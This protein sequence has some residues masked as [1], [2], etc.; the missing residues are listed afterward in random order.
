MADDVTIA[1]PAHPIPD[2]VQRYLNGE[3]ITS[4]ATDHQVSRQTIYNWLHNEVTDT[5]YPELVKQGLIAH[6]AHA[7]QLLMEAR[8]SIDVA[9]AR[10]VLNLSKWQ[11][12]RRVRMFSPKQEVTADTSLTIIVQRQ[13][14]P[15]RDITPIQPAISDDVNDIKG[16]E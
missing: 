5:H 8:T 1:K 10:E 7:E 12:E 9:R 13:G 3:R 14:E 2:L 16:L 15:P 11:L 4:L 6:L